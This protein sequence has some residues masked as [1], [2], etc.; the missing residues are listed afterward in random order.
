MR[1]RLIIFLLL[2]AGPAMPAA[3]QAERTLNA[4]ITR[5][6][7]LTTPD[8]EIPITYAPDGTYSGQLGETAFQGRWRIEGAQLCAS[9]SMSPTET[10]TEYPP[11]MGPGDAFEVNN[12]ALGRVTVTI[13]P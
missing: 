13:N 2:A 1:A 8:Y 12:P 6:V 5:G 3:G 7:V 9:S 11:G 10:C 4:V